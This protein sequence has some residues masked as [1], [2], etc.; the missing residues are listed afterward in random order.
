[1]DGTFSY[2][3]GLT[4]ATVVATLVVL[5]AAYFW[6]ARGSP[7][8]LLAVAAGL[9]SFAGAYSILNPLV[10]F[11]ELSTDWFIAELENGRVALRTASVLVGV[12]GLQGIVRLIR[13]GP[14]P[15]LMDSL[16]ALS[17]WHQRESRRLQRVFTHQALLYTSVMSLLWLLAVQDRTS[18]AIVALNWLVTFVVD[19]WAIVGHYSRHY[20]IRPSWRHTVQLQAINLLIA[21]FIVVVLASEQEGWIA[22]IGGLLV[23]ASFVVVPLGR[24]VMGTRQRLKDVRSGSRPRAPL[25]ASYEELWSRNRRLRE[26]FDEVSNRARGLREAHQATVSEADEV[27]RSV[28]IDQRR[29]STGGGDATEERVD[30]LVHAMRTGD[31]ERVDVSVRADP[32]L[33]AGQCSDGSSLLCRAALLERWAI[34]EVLRSH[35]PPLDIYDVIALNDLVHLETLLHNDPML[36]TLNHPALGSPLAFAVRS[37]RARAVE[38]LLRSGADP[39]DELDVDPPDLVD[40]AS[41]RMTAMMAGLLTIESPAPLLIEAIRRADVTTVRHLLDD[42]SNPNI[43]W[44][45]RSPLHYAAHKGYAGVADLLL[46]AGADPL[47]R[48]RDGGDPAQTADAAGHLALAELIRSHQEDALSRLHT[49]VAEKWRERGK[50]YPNLEG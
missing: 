43:L 36:W 48:V 2:E 16:Q 34:V 25:G 46:A 13:G 10:Q 42:G 21:V 32:A 38:L 15:F 45:G 35:D 41:R 14:D 3:S 31:D 33:A 28:W 37:G 47:L 49:F 9:G 20:Y 18:T 17:T 22:A 4:L 27:R 19:D 7:P 26:V 29:R 5:A 12:A 1:M 6:L 39:E 11:G 50:R 44:N 30:E 23:L 8:F 24:A 40:P